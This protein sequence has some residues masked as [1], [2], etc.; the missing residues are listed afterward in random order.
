MS[1]IK[2]TLKFGTTIALLLLLNAC[3]NAVKQDKVGKQKEIYVKDYFIKKETVQEKIK[4]D[5]S[6][7]KQKELYM[8]KSTGK[9]NYI[10][11]L[12]PLTGK[13]EGIG[14]QVLDSVTLAL[15]TSKVG[16]VRVLPID[17]KGTNNGA[18]LAAQEAINAGVKIVIGPVFSSET[19]AVAG[20]LQRAGI[21]TI[22][23]SNDVSVA[24]EDVY[25]FGILPEALMM[26]VVSFANKI[27]KKNF[28]LILPSSGYG[29]KMGK[30]IHKILEELDMVDMV[31]EYYP[32]N[33][34][35]FSSVISRVNFAKHRS[36]RVKEDGSIFILNR[37]DRSKKTDSEEDLPLIEKVMDVVY[38]DAKGFDLDTLISEIDKSSIQKGDTSIFISDLISNWS[39][40]LHYKM[41]GLMFP[42]V[43]SANISSSRKY[44]EKELEQTPIRVSLLAYDIV[45]V[46]SY[47]LKKDKNL[48]KQIHS[49]NGYNGILGD[50]R[51]T[52]SGIV[53]RRFGIYV[54]K[55]GYP[56]IIQNS[57]SFI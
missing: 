16:H 21:V 35:M 44:F 10:A 48:K 50:F 34:D 18:R 40:K 31:T 22:S 3:G 45:S 38:I 47:I 7:V 42:G 30:K 54:I 49:V 14:K 13:F 37:R 41:E 8:S 17:T 24:S 27:D 19:K 11:L 1:N 29:Y 2:Q 32:R 23:L 57:T 5:A 51:F 4:Q 15:F 6:E 12:V 43:V 55:N 33:K 20:M 28:G 9:I 52:S 39:G 26:T 56:E 53:Q 25:V 46:V 36:Y